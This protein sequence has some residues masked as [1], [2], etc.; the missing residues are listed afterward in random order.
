MNRIDFSRLWRCVKSRIPF[1]CRERSGYLVHMDELVNVS[2]AG[3]RAFER[4]MIS[5]GYQY[6]YFSFTERG[7]VSNMRKL[8]LL[9]GE[10]RQK[11]IR[12][13]DDGHVH[14]HDELAYEFDALGHVNGFTL[15]ECLDA[16]K[17]L[18]CATLKGNRYDYDR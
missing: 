4:K 2:R 18:I 17:L 8:Y 11:H 15:R 14:A 1:L 9:N 13:F 12:L 6:N 3:V 5:I 7:Q 10:V 16:D